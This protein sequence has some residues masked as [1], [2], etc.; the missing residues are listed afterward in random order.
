MSQLCRA[1]SR[2]RGTKSAMQRVRNLNLHEYQSKELMQKFSIAVQKFKPA[3]NAA[4]AEQAARE[5]SLLSR[6]LC[7]GPGAEA[8]H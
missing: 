4:Q 1:A 7:T 3:D 6:R 8:I 2:L 5:L